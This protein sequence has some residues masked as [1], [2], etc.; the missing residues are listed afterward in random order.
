MSSNRKRKNNEGRGLA[1]GLSLG[2]CIGTAIGTATGNIGLWLPIGLA[3]GVALGSSF[4]E[5]DKGEDMEK[6]SDNEEVS[7][8]IIIRF[9]REPVCMGD[10]VFNNIYQIEM[11]GDATLGD[12]MDIVRHGGNGNDW[13]VTSGYEWDVYTNIGKLAR[14]S[15]Q[16]EKVTYYEKDGDVQLA[17][18]DIRWVYAARDIDKVDIDKLEGV[19]RDRKKTI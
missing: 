18:L 9:N 2:L 17:D 8:K 14:I 6:D 10:D 4:K 19:F 13:P 3:L 1:F 11:P 7:D 12:L 5:S 16:T 15:P